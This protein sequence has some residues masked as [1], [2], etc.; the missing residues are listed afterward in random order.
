MFS[1]KYFLVI[2]TVISSI[3]ASA[4]RLGFMTQGGLT[5]EKGIAEIISAGT[6]ISGAGEKRETVFFLK[7]SK[8]RTC[9]I[10]P[11]IFPGVD[12]AQFALNAVKEKVLVTCKTNIAQLPVSAYNGSATDIWVSIEK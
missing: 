2:A 11:K 4:G 10:Y 7:D 12:P 3:N 8:N 6:A 5:D 9:T 1:V